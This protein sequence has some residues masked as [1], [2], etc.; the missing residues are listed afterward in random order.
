MKK[1]LCLLGCLV[2]VVNI[3]E[4]GFRLFDLDIRYK[5]LEKITEV[6]IA[7]TYFGNNDQCNILPI[8]DK[9]LKILPKAMRKHYSILSKFK[10][11]NFLQYLYLKHYICKFA[12]LKQRVGADDFQKNLLGIKKLG[13]S[14]IAKIIYDR[15]MSDGIIDKH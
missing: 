1:L 4:I 11:F 9:E 10:V 2:F 8:S 14:V 15:L 3:I 12:K 5:N 13:H 6:D 7:L